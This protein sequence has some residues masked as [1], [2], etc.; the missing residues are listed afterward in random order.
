MTVYCLLIVAIRGGD[1]YFIP[2]LNNETLNSIVNYLLIGVP[3][4]FPWRK[5]EEY[6]E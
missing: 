4:I 2:L 5:R 6:L 3:A 1:K